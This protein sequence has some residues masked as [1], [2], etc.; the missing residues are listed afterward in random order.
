MSLTLNDRLAQASKKFTKACEQIKL[1][2]QQISEYIGM[3]TYNDGLG[4]F[5]DSTSNVDSLATS[6]TTS[7]STTAGQQQSALNGYLIQSHR[8][9]ILN[10]HILNTADDFNHNLARENIRQKIETLQNFKSIFFMY[11]HQKAEEITKLQ[12]ELYGEEAVREAY[13]MAPPDVLLPAT[14]TNS[15]NEMNDESLLDT[16][17]TTNDSLDESLLTTLT[18]T[19]GEEE[20]ETSS[21]TTNSVQEEEL[22]TVIT[23]HSAAAT[24]NSSNWTYTQTFWNDSQSTVHQ[25]TTNAISTDT[26]SNQSAQLHLVEYSF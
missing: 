21:S 18:Q 7:T 1:L 12:C 11:A 15:N 4:P 24:S 2:K 19:E 22:D 6:A 9:T 8:T 5:V 14:V 13:D 17:D 23:N 25:E 10:S 3:F 20:E 16:I 26:A